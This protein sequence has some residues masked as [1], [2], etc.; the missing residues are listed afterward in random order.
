VAAIRDS[1]ATDSQSAELV[2][3]T[4]EEQ[5]LLDARLEEHRADPSAARPWAEVRAEILKQR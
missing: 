5:T 1:I 4:E 3:L 2:P